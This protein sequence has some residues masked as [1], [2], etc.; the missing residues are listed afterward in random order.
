MASARTTAM[1]LDGRRR[2]SRLDGRRC[3]SRVD[4]WRHDDLERGERPALVDTLVHLVV[5][6]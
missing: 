4:E 3:C 2:R 1:N 6:Y 5:E